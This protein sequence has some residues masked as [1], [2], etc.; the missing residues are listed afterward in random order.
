MTRRQAYRE[1]DRRTRTIAARND[2]RSFHDDWA[3]ISSADPRWPTYPPPTLYGYPPSPSNNAF[4]NGQHHILD[5]NC[6]RPSDRH[7]GRRP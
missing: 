2:M 5:A 4:Y 6:P 1:C 3:K 7:T